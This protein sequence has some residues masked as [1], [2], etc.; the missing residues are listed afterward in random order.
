MNI[1]FE[2]DYHEITKFLA[3]ECEIYGYVLFLKIKPKF[4]ANR[5]RVINYHN[6]SCFFT[7]IL[8]L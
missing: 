7:G 6:E 5:N 8:V 2:L 4:V 3:F 1:E